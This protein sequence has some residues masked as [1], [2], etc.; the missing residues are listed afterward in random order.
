[1]NNKSITSN[2]SSGIEKTEQLIEIANEGLRYGANEE[3]FPWSSRE[4]FECDY[5]GVRE[6]L[7]SEFGGEP[8]TR[9][10]WDLYGDFFNP[11]DEEKKRY[12]NSYAEYVDY[13]RG[14]CQDVFHAIIDS[15][16]EYK[17]FLESL[18]AAAE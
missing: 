15:L 17:S 13:C 14:K 10:S 7:I 6:E 9:Q 11:D 4:E 2:L 12:N 1:M 8:F 18:Y 5:E 16:K 3:V